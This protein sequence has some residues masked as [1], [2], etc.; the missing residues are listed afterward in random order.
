MVDIPDI[1]SPQRDHWRFLTLN[2]L[3]FPIK[4]DMHQEGCPH[5]IKHN[6]F[7]SHKQFFKKKKFTYFS[8]DHVVSSSV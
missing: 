2:S 4:F 7:I 6:A 3:S 8:T 1:C 5:F